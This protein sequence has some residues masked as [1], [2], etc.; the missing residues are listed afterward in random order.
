MQHN[1]AVFGMDLAPGTLS[2]DVAVWVGDICDPAFVQDVILA[3]CPTHIFHMAALTTAYGDLEALYKVNVQGT[4]HVLDAVHRAGLDPVIL[5]PG[6]CAV[7]GMIDPDDLPIRE[8]QPFR[9]SSSYAVSKITQEML[10]YTYY[11]QYGLKVIRTRAFNLVGP[12]QPSSLVGS[13]F[14]Q[15]IAQIEA[16]RIEP[17]LRVGDL[18]A[19]RDFVDVR[20]VVHAYRLAA[21]RGQ[22]GDAYNVCSGVGISIRTCLDELLALTKI[23]VQVVQEPARMRPSD[24]PVS[25]GDSS[26]LQGQTGWRPIIPLR[27]SLADLLEDWRQRIKEA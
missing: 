24:I 22:P 17:V 3:V 19:Q 4:R 15:Q 23:S 9:P 1:Y 12:G 7:Y 13:A 11:A 18:T 26:L 6:S 2:A 5:I 25:V 8:S 27:Q 10:A 14:T 20:D 21:E 16:G